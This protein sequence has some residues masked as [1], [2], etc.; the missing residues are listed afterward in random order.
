[1]A[2]TVRWG[3]SLEQMADDLFAKLNASKVA[4]PSEV[5]QTRDCIVVPNRIQEAWLQQRFL[6]DAPRKTIPHVLANVD[7]ALLNFFVQDWLYRMDRPAT[8]NTRPD[9]EKHPFSVKSMRWRMYDILQHAELEG[10]LAP[11]KRYILHDGKRDARKCFKLAGRIAK[12]FDEY[13]T[14]RPEIMADWTR[15]GNTQTDAGTEW[16]PVFWRM[17]VKDK[18]HETH[19]SAFQR[20]EGRI[21]NCAIAHV[22][23]RVFVFAPSMLPPTHLYFFRLLGDWVPLDFYMFN[24][25]NTD[26]F[27]RAIDKRMALHDRPPDDGELLNAENPLLSAYGRGCRDLVAGALD[28]TGGQIEDSFKESDGLTVLDA[29][30]RAI[31]NCEGAGSKDPRKQDGSIQLHLCHGKMREVEIL[32]DQLLACFDEM[33]GLQP[34]HIQVQVGDLNEYAPYIEAVFS[35]ENPNAPK[36]IPFALADRV[37]AGESR[38]AEAFQQLLELADSR[39]TAAEILELLR[40]ENVALRFG[41]TPSDV[42]DAGVWLNE[43]GVRWGRNVEHREKTSGAKF[44]A[45]TT[46]QYGLDRLFLGYAMGQE[47]LPDT[48][49]NVIPSDCVEGDGAVLLGKLASFY[50][51]LVE[52]AEFSSRSHPLAAWTDRLEQLVDDF[53]V[54]DNETYR[55][56][57]II[58]G[59]IRLLRTTGEAAAFDKSAP[60]A[61]IRDFLAGRLGETTGGSDINRNTVVFSSLRPGSST[62]R[63]VQCL[64]GMGDGLFPRVESRPAYDLLRAARKMGDR[65]A[66]I[67]DRL[68][69]LEAILNARERLL[70]FYP[71]F[72]EE[73][74]SPLHQSVAVHELTEYLTRRFGKDA[75]TPPFNT[76]SHR[77]HPWHP[78]YFDKTKPLFSF[79]GTN[80]NTAK[81]LLEKSAVTPPVHGARAPA[82]KVELDDLASFFKHPGEYYFKHILGAEPITRG[83]ELSAEAEPFE[84]DNLQTWH[85][86][87]DVLRSFLDG[88]DD[89]KRKA[90][91]NRLA[92]DGQIPLGWG[93]K[94]R[95]KLIDEVRDLLKQGI[96]GF[97]SLSDALTLQRKADQRECRIEIRLNGRDVELSGRV[98]LIA[99]PSEKQ[100]LD[101]SHSS[102]AAKHLFRTWFAHLLLCAAGEPV[103]SVNIQRKDTKL[104]IRHFQPMASADDAKKILAEYLDIYFSAPPLPPYTPKVAWAYLENRHDEASYDIAALEKAAKLWSSPFNYSEKDD[105]YYAAVFPGKGPLE[106]EINFI[107]MAKRIFGPLREHSF[108]EKTK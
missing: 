33:K 86:R 37:T 14:Y 21:A 90:L 54:S 48:L 31:Y 95:A 97:A 50:N 38:I 82:T 10:L 60:V 66:T 52:F 73:D 99:L 56:V 8:E 41:L 24:P 59:A 78:E 27:D 94:Q 11:L 57:G 16:E 91:L 6:F 62:P 76:F 63:R 44:G 106:N 53:F 105:P 65:S 87:E 46:W 45:E 92:A 20:M 15:G 93:E 70:I 74:N 68:A 84:M 104:I 75:N 101:F 77:L 58:K 2:L 71:A 35:A 108:E 13:Q 55:D 40:C 32:R 107:E 51:K 72:S 42:D 26:W 4:S 67:E 9:P 28:L 49:T 85:A 47:E 3:N 23:R 17:L 30:Q 1:M 102:F 100:A 43:A 103:T 19:I 39:F 89:S 81:A 12:I 34:R 5:F 25:S 36:T 88:E 22:Y 18:E 29:L 7:F 98:A 80:L 69:F 64:L 79:S 83:D 96:P 61:I